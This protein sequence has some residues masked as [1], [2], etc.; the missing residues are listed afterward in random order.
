VTEEAE[1]ELAVAVAVEVRERRVAGDRPAVQGG[2]RIGAASKATGASVA[3]S[4]VAIQVA[5]GVALAR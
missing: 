3:L 1:P 4:T 5:T 2:T